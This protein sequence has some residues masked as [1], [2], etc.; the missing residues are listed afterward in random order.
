[1]IVIASFTVASAVESSDQMKTSSNFNQNKLVTG[2]DP[3]TH[4]LDY[5]ESD[6]LVDDALELGVESIIELDLDKNGKKTK[7]QE[8]S[9]SSSKQQGKKQ[10]LKFTK[11][12]KEMI[13]PEELKGMKGATG[14]VP[15][16]DLITVKN[17]GRMWK[18]VSAHVDCEL[19][20]WRV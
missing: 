14:Q 12:Y 2:T 3:E 10:K 1:M 9:S 15:D 6:G 7:D 4:M 8:K 17:G 11:A 13:L 19:S 16:E 18:K 20:S 5:D